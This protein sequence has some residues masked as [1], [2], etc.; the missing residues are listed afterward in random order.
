MLIR[1]NSIKKAQGVIARV[2]CTSRTIKD[3]ILERP[4]GY[5]DY[6][7]QE[8]EIIIGAPLSAEDY[9][10]ADKFMLL[11]MQP[12]VKNMLNSKPVSKTRAKN[13]Q[14]GTST[15]P[16]PGPE[17]TENLVSLTAFKEGGIYYT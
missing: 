7:H 9:E 16:I 15:L 8:M 10:C 5:K 6:S 2:L 3:R 14:R 4:G 1:T 17:E 12:Q 13:T 11:L